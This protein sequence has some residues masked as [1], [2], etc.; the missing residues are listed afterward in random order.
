MFKFGR[1]Y[2]HDAD[3]AHLACCGFLFCLLL[4]RFGAGT[5][6]P[7]VRFPFSLTCLSLVVYLLSLSP[8]LGS[9]S[10]NSS[11]NSARNAVLLL[12]VDLWEMEVFVSIIGVVIHDIF[13]GGLVNQ[14]SHGKSLDSFILWDDSSAIEAIDHITVT[15]VLLTSSVVSSL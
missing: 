2:N 12:E 9:N 6:N 1:D 10:D 11:M 5:A 8:S 14:F 3:D 15:L 4:T 13:S 7:P